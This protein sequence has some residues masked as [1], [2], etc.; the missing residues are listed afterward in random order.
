MD[1][2]HD[3]LE[4]DDLSV[5]V[6]AGVPKGFNRSLQAFVK[7]EH[8]EEAASLRVRDDLSP[9]LLARIRSR[10]RPQSATGPASSALWRAFRALS[11]AIYHLRGDT[12]R[13][14]ALRQLRDDVEAH[15][16]EVSPLHRREAAEDAA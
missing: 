2:A 1:M 4:R 10:Y 12:E 11:A 14:G 15:W 9:W 16:T 7:E 5:F 6:V 13:A 3:W 8:G